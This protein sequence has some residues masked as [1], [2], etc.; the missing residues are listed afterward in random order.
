MQASNLVSNAKGIYL[1]VVCKDAK[2]PDTIWVMEAWD[3]KEDH[4]NSLKIEGVKEL[5]GRAMP[6]IDGKPEGT[7]L[8]VIGGKGVE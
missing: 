6:L 8:N 5:I 4:D 3:T 1:Y 2:D 7:V